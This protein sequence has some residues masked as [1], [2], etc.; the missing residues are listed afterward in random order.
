MIQIRPDTQ[1]E[2]S[3]E[4][5]LCA[6]FSVFGRKET[7]LRLVLGLRGVQDDPLYQRSERNEAGFR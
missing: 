1:V 6:A 7:K 4:E 5:Y 2:I 3:R